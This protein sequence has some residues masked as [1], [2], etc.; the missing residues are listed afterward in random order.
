MATTAHRRTSLFEGYTRV[1]VAV[2]GFLAFTYVAC[3]IWD[4]VFAS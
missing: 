1:G 3:S 4:G 2:G